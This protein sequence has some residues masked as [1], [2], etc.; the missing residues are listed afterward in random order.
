MASIEPISDCTMQ[1][2]VFWRFARQIILMECSMVILPPVTFF[3][4]VK[5]LSG[6]VPDVDFTTVKMISYA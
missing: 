3:T 2:T 6:N 1:L 5:K 4:V